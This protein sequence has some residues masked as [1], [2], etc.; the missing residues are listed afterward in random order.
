MKFYLKSYGKESCIEVAVS[1]ILDLFNIIQDQTT[2]EYILLERD[3]IFIDLS[4]LLTDINIHD[5]S[6]LDKFLADTN[7]AW[8]LYK[9]DVCNK[10][11]LLVYDIT[12][13]DNVAI[14]TDIPQDGLLPDEGVMGL[15]GITYNKIT[16]DS[17]NDP[18]VNLKNI[19]LIING[20]VLNKTINKTGK[21][22]EF[23]IN[24]TPLSNDNHVIIDTTDIGG[25]TDITIEDIVYKESSETF[26]IKTNESMEN[27]PWLI[28]N[29]EL[30]LPETEKYSSVLA[31][32]KNSFYLSQ[33]HLRYIYRPELIE[34]KIITN[35][36]EANFILN[37][38][39]SS[40]KILGPNKACSVLTLPIED[41]LYTK[42]Y[43]R[44]SIDGLIDQKY[45]G[46]LYRNGRIVSFR[47][48]PFEWIQLNEKKELT[49][50]GTNFFIG[51]IGTDDKLK[52]FKY[53]EKVPSTESNPLGEY[54]ST[55][56][57]TWYIVDV[58]T[59]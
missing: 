58:S 1:H 24:D 21:I 32:S 8:E 39:K 14:E 4:L 30:C 20:K 35:I 19:L 5:Y 28:L 54:N 18:S 23:K 36:E 43:I 3:G 55:T 27:K 10:K 56:N 9:T 33:A 25:Y 15:P 37:K 44:D 49:I 17:T 2:N 41:H 57:D 38:L 52:F 11:R 51:K 46:I 6:D 48:S 42:R 29:N 22:A 53:E 50:K 31:L 34:N 16:I 12:E 13:L 47:N 45:K 7:I 59:T 40:L 26:L